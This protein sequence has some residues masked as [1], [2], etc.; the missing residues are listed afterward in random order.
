MADVCKTCR[1]RPIRVN[2]H[3]IRTD[4]KPDSKILFVTDYP[5]E[6]DYEYGMVL[7]GLHRRA[8]FL[9][10]LM[11]QIKLD[12]DEVSHATVMRCI[13]KSKS[14]LN[15]EVYL[16]CGQILIDEIKDSDIRAILCFGS[17]AG[18]L[19]TGDKVSS[20]EKARG[21]ILDS[22]IPEAFCMVTYAMGVLV[23]ST[24]CRGCGKNVQPLL[25]R[26]DAHLLGK[27]LRRRENEERKIKTR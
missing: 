2:T 18:T 13:T 12:Q 8:K 16:H 22:I 6:E 23:D 11:K 3:P 5:M 21:T 14:I 20:I 24:G 25:A 17:V 9:H 7:S 1:I 10:S 27:E 26:K 19:F 4:L 15:M